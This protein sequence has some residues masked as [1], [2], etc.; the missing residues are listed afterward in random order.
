VVV[1]SEYLD[2]W[3]LLA[4]VVL[5]PEIE[6]SHIWQFAPTGQYSAKSAYGAMF[7]G[8]VQFNPWVRIEKSKAPGSVNSSCGWQHI[9]SA[10]Q[11]IGLPRG[12]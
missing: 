5:Q 6:D 10:G 4:E 11:P 12:V 8:A 1:L 3:D 7:I 9:V 2:L